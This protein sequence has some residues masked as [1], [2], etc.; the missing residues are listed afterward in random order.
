MSGAYTPVRL[1]KEAATIFCTHAVLR[2]VLKRHMQRL[3]PNDS[4]RS[5]VFCVLFTLGVVLYNSKLVFNVRV[6]VNRFLVHAQRRL[7][8]PTQA[9]LVNLLANVVNER[10][11]HGVFQRAT[12]A[13][14]DGDVGYDVYDDAV[15]PAFTQAVEQECAVCFEFTD[16]NLSFCCARAFVLCARC[17]A[18]VQRCLICG[19]RARLA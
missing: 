15:V 4:P 9:A 10:N 18:S 17:R 12:A 13:P 6:L 5:V 14:E 11:V 19:E 16:K 7:R 2:S 8:E 3:D 1:G